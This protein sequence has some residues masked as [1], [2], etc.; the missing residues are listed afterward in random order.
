MSEEGC[1]PER[2]KTTL[3]GC[4]ESRGAEPEGRSPEGSAA[5]A[6]S[7]AR[8]DAKRR[9]NTDAKQL[10]EQEAQ[11]PKPITDKRHSTTNHHSWPPAPL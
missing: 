3:A 6:H 4:R 7:R 5:Q 2:D 11:D 1:R 10:T 9:E 8:Q